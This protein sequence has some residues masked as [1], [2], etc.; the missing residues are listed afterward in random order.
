MSGLSHPRCLLPDLVLAGA[1]HVYESLRRSDDLGWNAGQES[2]YDLKERDKTETIMSVRRQRYFTTYVRVQ[3]WKA[4]QLEVHP[5]SSENSDLSMQFED[6]HFQ[7]VLQLLRGPIFER[8]K[9]KKHEITKDMVKSDIMTGPIVRLGYDFR[10]KPE[11]ETCLLPISQPLYTS[12]SEEDQQA[13]TCGYRSL[14]LHHEKL[15]VYSCLLKEKSSHSSMAQIMSAM[16]TECSSSQQPQKVSISSYFH[17]VVPPGG[18]PAKSSQPSTSTPGGARSHVTTTTGQDEEATVP[19]SDTR[20]RKL[21]SIIKRSGPKLSKKAKKVKSVKEVMAPRNPVQ[22]AGGHVE[23]IASDT[24]FTRMSFFG[25]LPEQDCAPVDNDIITKQ[26]PTGEMNEKVAE[27]PTEPKHCSEPKLCSRSE[28]CKMLDFSPEKSHK[29]CKMKSMNDKCD[30]VQINSGN[31]GDRSYGSED[32]FMENCDEVTEDEVNIIE[33]RKTESEHLP[34]KERMDSAICRPVC[35]QTPPR[36]DITTD[37]DGSDCCIMPET[38]FHSEQVSVTDQIPHSRSKPALKDTEFKQ[39]S[40]DLIQRRLTVGSNETLPSASFIHEF[41][42][43]TP[44]VKT[45]RVLDEGHGDATDPKRN[46]HVETESTG[47][48]KTS[49]EDLPQISLKKRD[50]SWRRSLALLMKEKDAPHLVQEV[51]DCDT[52]DCDLIEELEELPKHPMILTEDLRHELS[53]VSSEAEL[54]ESHIQMMVLGSE[55]YLRSIF[56]GKHQCQRHEDY[57]KGGKARLNLNYQV[58]L[59]MFTE[60]QQDAVMETLMGIF[61]KRH[62][63]YMDYILKVLLPEMMIRILMEV[64]H[65]TYDDTEALMSGAIR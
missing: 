39:L 29:I 64:K 63:K 48:D 54:T 20:K 8:V 18:S 56:T 15:V 33:L 5:M 35:I 28:S 52:I 2:G 9:L 42:P 43:N 10:A 13:W 14:S 65:M 59:A 22:C 44:N 38:S 17:R 7:E 4:L 1:S 31:Y 55:G 32:I 12:D 60:P 19:P 6:R 27:N 61:C 62:H 16:S 53:Q 50:R 21:K 49:C 40:V 45:G 11:Y 51:I 36:Y 37:T 34:A 3:K 46:R 24:E 30:N 57:K 25:D 58:N 26:D 41:D 47:S 23:D